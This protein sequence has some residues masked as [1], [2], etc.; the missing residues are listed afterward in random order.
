MPRP[1]A[2]AT[3]LLWLYA[4]WSYLSITW[5]GQKGD[6]WDGANRTVL[7][8][9]VFS[10]FAVWPMR[11]RAAATVLGAFALAVA[12]VGLIELLKANSSSH[13]LGYF[14]DARFAEP[15]GYP[16]ANVCLW[17]AAFL[18]CV[19][20][21]SRRELHPAL[22][23]LFLA[24][25]SL[26]GGLA[27]MGQTRGWLYAAPLVILIYLVASPDRV[28][29]AVALIAVLAA[30]T[31]Y[32]GPVEHVHDSFAHPASVDGAL[33]HA[34][35][36]LLW[37]SLVLGV[38]T[39]AVAYADRRVRVSRGLAR[40]ANRG[41]LTAGAIVLVVGGVVL[42]ASAGHPVSRLQSAWNDFKRGPQP[43]G[44]EARFNF[45]LGSNRYDFWRVAW[46]EARQHPVGGVGA[47][48]FQEQYFEHRHSN[49]TPL[50]PHS[51]GFR[52]LA[53]TG[54]V[55]AALL[56]AAIASALVA[57]WGAIRRR[58]GMGAATAAGAAAWF[59]YWLAHGSVDW[60]WEF[61]ALGLGALA[62]L[63]LATSLLPRPAASRAAARPLVR[64]TGP[65]AVAVVAAAIV[66]L[67]MLSP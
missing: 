44:S 3:G 14:L 2:V 19:T 39:A 46:L 30:A 25:A 15:V 18:P 65:L 23:G 47:D 32:R 50:Y 62:M 52:A 48:N 7:Y 29:T 51:I 60:F 33:A 57:A 59:L 49:E 67:G 66:A 27:L 16:N 54:F 38:L 26:L 10:L 63:G 42:A 56:F 34:T 8:A 61:P 1:V 6:A 40:R 22:R 21:G 12:G 37:T 64:S 13:V 31:V 58:S 9:V 36:A 55:G 24:S 5:A 11:A 17:F 53:S 43:T 20:L 41:L 4:A 45:A 35:S 28:R